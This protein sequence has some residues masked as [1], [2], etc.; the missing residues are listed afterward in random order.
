MGHSTIGTVLLLL[1]LPT[2]ELL[3]AFFLPSLL[4]VP[5]GLPGDLAGV[6]AALAG[7]AALAAAFFPPLVEGPDGVLAGD[8]EFF[9]A[10]ERG[11]GPEGP[12]RWSSE[13]SAP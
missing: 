8:D 13:P 7:V 5:L 4:V 1:L 9:L 10:G 12:G 6:V 11:L 2:D 3:L